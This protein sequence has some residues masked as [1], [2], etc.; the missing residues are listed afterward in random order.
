[1]ESRGPAQL[2]GMRYFH[3][4]SQWHGTAH[5]GLLGVSKSQDILKSRIPTMVLTGLPR[6][7]GIRYLELH[8]AQS[9]GMVS[10]GRLV[11]E[12]EK[13]NWRIPMMVLTGLHLRLGMPCLQLGV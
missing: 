6:H 8:A 5:Y 2:L 1:M 3:I 13:I 10:S 9:H 4:A 11:E 7:L 12:E